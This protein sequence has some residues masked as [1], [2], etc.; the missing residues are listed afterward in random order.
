MGKRTQQTS[1]KEAKAGQ[2]KR[3]Q[4]IKIRNRVWLLLVEIVIFI[5]L[6]FIGYILQKHGKLDIQS[7][8][9][10]F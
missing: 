3:N 2:I 8:L 1:L 4:R 6:L 5:V 9:R 7:I 10:Y